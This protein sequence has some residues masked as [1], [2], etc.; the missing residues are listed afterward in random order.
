[1]IG[2]SPTSRIFVSGIDTDA[3]KT[4]AS[5]IL[6]KGLNADYWKPVQA[7]TDPCTDT[8]FVRNVTGMPPHHFHSEGYRLALPASPHAAA[9]AEGVQI[10]EAA[11]RPPS[12][13]Q[14]LVIEGAG[15]LMVPLRD[16]FLF[17][18]WL[19]S[20]QIPTLL[21]VKT[22]LGC[23]NHS[24]LTLEALRKRGVPLLGI[25]FNEGGRPESEAVILRYAEAPLLGR[26]PLLEEITSETLQTVFDTSFNLKRSG[27]SLDIG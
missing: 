2:I 13:T 15:G 6:V 16:D 1:M 21:V 19:E 8:E 17:I 22:Y 25:V 9:A 12:T 14:P 5:A 20:Q 18:D 7:G 26:I 23:I 11:L 27:N 10:S 4:L 24:L 3:G